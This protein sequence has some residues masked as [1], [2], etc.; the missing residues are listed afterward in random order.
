MRFATRTAQ[1]RALLCMLA[2]AL[3]FATT[4]GLMHR[5]LHGL[6]SSPAPAVAGAAVEE[7]TTGNG[8]HG[9]SALFGTHSDAECRLYDQLSHGPAAFGVPAVVLPVL[10]PAAVF[11]YLEGEVLARWVA[12]FD[13]RGPPSAR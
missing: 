2:F 5:T 10:L 1:T 6:G 8:A 3:W 11:L 13:A 9:L 4:L 7:R 12:L